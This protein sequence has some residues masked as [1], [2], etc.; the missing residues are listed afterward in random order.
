MTTPDAT[1]FRMIMI[2]KPLNRMIHTA[3]ISSQVAAGHQ[4]VLHYSA[5]NLTSS[6]LISN[7]SAN[8]EYP[9]VPKFKN[10]STSHVTS[11]K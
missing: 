9:F 5:N 1:M 4:E 3:I 2:I 6:R 10:N 8:T 7:D 11:K